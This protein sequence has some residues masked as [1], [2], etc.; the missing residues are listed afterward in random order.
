MLKRRS[1]RPESRPGSLYGLAPRPSQ[2]SRPLSATKMT[3]SA[4]RPDRA[5]SRL[6]RSSF[7]RKA[8]AVN[9]PGRVRRRVR[10]ARGGPR[11][12]SR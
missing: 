8:Q 9:F 1:H 4:P 3:D 10:V 6:R 2:H 11:G 12:A 7:L 5:I